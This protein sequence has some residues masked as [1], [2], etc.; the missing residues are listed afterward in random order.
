MSNDYTLQIIYDVPKHAIDDPEQNAKRYGFCDILHVY[1]ASKNA[2]LN[3]DSGEWKIND[4]INAKFLFIHVVDV[5]KGLQ[6]I[7]LESPLL[8]PNGSPNVVFA[9]E[10]PYIK[11]RA[12]KFRVNLD[13]FNDTDLLKDKQTTVHYDLFKTFCERKT[14]N[15]KTDSDQDT[16]TLLTNDDL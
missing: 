13:L 11:H 4:K 3:S 9:K 6:I 7:N 16:F 1:P 15:V 2:T 10:N 8:K 14:S 12:R 5:P